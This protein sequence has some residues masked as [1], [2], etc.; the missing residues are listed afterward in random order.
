MN[1]YEKFLYGCYYAVVK[2]KRFTND[3]YN[4]IVLMEKVGLKEYAE[5][6]ERNCCD[7]RSREEKSKKPYCREEDFCED[8][9]FHLAEINGVKGNVV[10]IEFQWGKGFTFGSLEDY[11][12]EEVKILSVEDLINATGYESEFGKDYVETSF[13]N[14]MEEKDKNFAEI[15]DDFCSWYDWRLIKY[16]NFQYNILDIQT[17]EF[18][19]HFGDEDNINGNLRD[20]I[21][22]VFYKSV[23][24][25]IDEEE[26]EDIN[27]IEKTINEF[28]FYAKKY[29][30]YD[31]NYINY[32]LKWKEEE[33][34]YL[35]NEEK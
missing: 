27:Y 6:F 16:S 19:G 21:E 35:K 15:L 3:L 20:C 33:I 9:F 31:E 2:I 29:N 12:A 10:C 28:I 26:H 25:F 13:I 11:Q 32:L 22:R 23:D 18:A 30:L 24:Y 1:D 8:Y 5:N 17:D 4:F 7:I 14:E 34:E